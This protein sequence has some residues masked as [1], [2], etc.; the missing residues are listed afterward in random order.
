MMTNT[1]NLHRSLGLSGAIL[2]GLGSIVGTGVYVSVGIAAGVT[3]ASAL[4]AVMLAALV[5]TFNGLN[6]AQL[7]ANHPV[8]GGT[9]EYAYRLLNPWLGFTAGWTFLLAKSASAA[10]AALGF[11]SYLLTALQADLNLR[12]PLALLALA[13]LTAV[14]LGGVQRSNAFN[15]GIVALAIGALLL[16]AF[17]GLSALDSANFAPF[18]ST[19]Q[20]LPDF[21]QA[22]ALMFVAY[23]GYGRIATM[24]EEVREP[25][26]T[27]PRAIVGA[28]LAS[29][30]LYG[31]VALA[32]VGAVG[33][34]TLADLTVQGRAPLELIARQL[35][36]PLLAQIVAIGAM[37]AM[38]SVLLNLVLGLSRVL[39]AMGRRCDMPP[40]VARLN[41]ANTTP[42]YAV[43]GVS[44][45]ISL[46]IL[47][48]DIAATWSFSA[49][50]VLIY[51]AITDLAALRLK[52]E[53]RLFPRWVA[54]F[55]LASC[56]FLA[57]WV[58]P[59]IWLLGLTL[60]VGGLAWQRAARRLFGKL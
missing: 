45:L 7:A 8:S 39:L 31:L 6:S 11:A 24:G 52:I 4:L 53:Q 32:A 12:V 46:L 15:L 57:F 47:S 37:A 48:G 14:A 16:F 41:A 33:A 10:T 21:L 54:L 25:R 38:L 58:D 44:L 17:F 26:R 43:L 5:A 34:A 13:I 56:A 20:P 35:G 28:L 22:V 18:F 49:F 19:D 29:A 3:G 42:P 23:T 55:G 36:Q 51:Y 40:L 60:I 1:P 50:S 59:P 30:L 9:Y 2:L 27:I